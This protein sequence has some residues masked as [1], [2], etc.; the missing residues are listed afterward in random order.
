L[1]RLGR[2]RVSKKKGKYSI[3]NDSKG[4]DCCNNE[5]SLTYGIEKKAHVKDDCMLLQLNQYL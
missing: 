4:S 3:S 1:R 5:L 2:E